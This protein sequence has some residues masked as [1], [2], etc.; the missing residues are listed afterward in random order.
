MQLDSDIIM[1]RLLHNKM[2]YTNKETIPMLLG[3]KPE[4]WIGA[5]EEELLRRIPIG[6]NVTRQEI[7]E[8]FPKGDEHRALQRDIKYAMSNLERQMLVVKQFEDVTG[9]PPPTLLIPSSVMVSMRLL[10]LKVP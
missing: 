7:M 6:E 9:P 8:G 5:M 10:I 3:L 2:G 1:G 4:P